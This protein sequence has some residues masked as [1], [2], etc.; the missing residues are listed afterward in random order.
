MDYA[1]KPTVY[2][3]QKQPLIGPNFLH[4]PFGLHVDVFSHQFDEN[5]KKTQ[6]VRLHG[7][8]SSWLE[9]VQGINGWPF[10]FP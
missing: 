8:N 2:G 1:T 7:V 6:V 5:F 9:C 3:N 10:W 4:A